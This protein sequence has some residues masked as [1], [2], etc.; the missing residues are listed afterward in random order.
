VLAAA[1]QG[2]FLGE[3]QEMRRDQGQWVQAPQQSQHHVDDLDG[4]GWVGARAEF[5]KQDQCSR[6]HRLEQRPEAHQLRSQAPFALIGA[7]QFDDG[8]EE[9]RHQAHAGRPAGHVEP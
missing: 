8:G 1:V 7:V 5:V 6:G 3:V 2:E 9:P 4:L